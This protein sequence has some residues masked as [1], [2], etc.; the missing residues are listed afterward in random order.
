MGQRKNTRIKMVLPLRLWGTDATGKTFMLMAHTLDVSPTGARV[1]GV[2]AQITPGDVVGVQYRMQKQ[3][4]RVAWVGR[5]G[6]SRDSRIG[7]EYLDRDRKILALEL[8]ASEG[9]DDYE[10]PEPR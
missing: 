3:Q 2:R 8:P 5:P 6:P 1:A 4:F 9:A 7:I 10:P